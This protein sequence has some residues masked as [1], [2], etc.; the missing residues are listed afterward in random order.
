MQGITLDIAIEN[1]NIWLEASR[2]VAISQSYRIGSRSLTR[3]DL[4]EIRKQIQYW[5]AQISQLSRR[6]RNRV[7][8]VVV[9]DG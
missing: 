7:Y 3:A 5:N 6:G 4:G 8:R 2:E 1:L 9:K